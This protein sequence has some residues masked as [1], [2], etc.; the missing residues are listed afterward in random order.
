M[1]SIVNNIFSFFE[2]QILN[3]NKTKDV[4]LLHNLRDLKLSLFTLTVLYQN[5][6]IT[7]Y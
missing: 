4:E 5:D 2:L 7:L 3:R 6:S 1:I